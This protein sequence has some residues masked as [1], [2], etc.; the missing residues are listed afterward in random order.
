MSTI[1]RFRWIILIALALLAIGASI[2]AMTINIGSYSD[3]YTVSVGVFESYENAEKLANIIKSNDYR[4]WI[5]SYTSNGETN[6]RVYL[7]AFESK[8]KAEEF[9]QSVQKKLPFIANY[10]IVSV[11]QNQ[12]VIIPSQ[13]TKAM[14]PPINSAVTIVVNPQKEIQAPT[15]IINTLEPVVKQE[16]VIQPPI[17]LVKKINPNAQ[18]TVQ[19][20]KFVKYENAKNLYNILKSANCEPWLKSYSY[21]GNVAY[22]LYT[23]AFESK[24]KA[25]VF[26]QS[27][28]KK[29]PIISN[30]IIVKANLKQAITIP[31]QI[32]EIMP[33]TI[34]SAV[35]PLVIPQKQIQAPTTT[36]NDL[37]P[38]LK[39]K[40]VVQPPIQLAKKINS[41]TKYA[42]RV[43]KFTKY[44]N[45]KKLYNMLKS[46]NCDPWLKAYSYKG[47]TTYWLYAGAFES[48][49]K[50]EEFARLIKERLSYIDDYVIMGIN[51]GIN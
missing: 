24:Y 42:V 40:P 1:K 16:P 8:N 20:G 22:W 37:R 30:Y 11:K 50:A 3:P 13:I 4:P 10:E 33:P 18:Y 27:V 19:V 7:G 12:A 9:A 5:R 34:N 49:D 15:T 45:A 41:V 2:Y 44:E 25:E 48:K 51:P 6:H 26:A 38:V 36:V 43:G 17:Q 29:L 47:N 31:S 23:G 39:Q 46:A 32:E 28:Q 21:K 35:K 14:P